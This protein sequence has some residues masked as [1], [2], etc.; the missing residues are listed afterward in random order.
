MAQ[1]AIGFEHRIDDI[2]SNP[3]VTGVVLGLL[4]DKVPL[5]K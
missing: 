1:L 5:V 4:S 3:E 2:Q